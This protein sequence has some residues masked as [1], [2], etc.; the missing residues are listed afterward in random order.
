MHWWVMA[1]SGLVSLH[2]KYIPK[3]D[4]KGFPP[5]R[6]GVTNPSKVLL[7]KYGD[8]RLAIFQGKKKKLNLPDLDHSL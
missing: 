1:Y 3:D 6:V 8:F 7:G 2:W 5:A 4:D